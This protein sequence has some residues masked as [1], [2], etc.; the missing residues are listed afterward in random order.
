VPADGEHDAARH[1]GGRGREPAGPWPVRPAGQQ[2]Q[3]TGEDWRG[4]DGDDRPDGHA[5]A[6]GGGE[7][8]RLVPGDSD[9]AE[10]DQATAARSARNQAAQR[11]AAQGDG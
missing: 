7:E 1:R 3:D 8:G 11:A 4:A 2:G 10:C 9:R 6:G 5:G